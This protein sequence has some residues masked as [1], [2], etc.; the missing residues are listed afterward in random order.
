MCFFHIC[1]VYCPLL[2]VLYFAL[3]LL[4]GQQ[5]VDSVR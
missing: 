5:T 3:F 1:P 4:I 2:F